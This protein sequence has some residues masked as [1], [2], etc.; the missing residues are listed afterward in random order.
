MWTVLATAI[1]A[2]KQD[3]PRWCITRTTCNFP[4]EQIVDYGCGEST[5]QRMELMPARP[6]P[7]V[8]LHD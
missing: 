5:N 7:R 6:E 2:E 8:P 4:N 1:L 3:E